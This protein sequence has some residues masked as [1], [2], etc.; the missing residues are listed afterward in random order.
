MPGE[1]S[2]MRQEMKKWMS[3]FD[4]RW[5]FWQKTKDMLEK[6]N[7][8]CDPLYAPIDLIH[9]GRAHCSKGPVDG[10]VV[11]EVPSQTKETCRMAILNSTKEM[12]ERILNAG[13]HYDI[14]EYD[15]GRFSRGEPTDIEFHVPCNLDD[16]EKELAILYKAG[17]DK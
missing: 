7:Y 8:E 1:D 17:F 6:G 3:S 14:A 13:R 12:S 5:E 15:R 9:A 11:V 10:R 16:L 4:I 2:P